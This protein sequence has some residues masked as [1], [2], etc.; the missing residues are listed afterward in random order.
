MLEVK[1][2]L[3]PPVVF[4]CGLS[5]VK[6]NRVRSSPF[7]L[8]GTMQ[9]PQW[10]AAT[11]RRRMWAR[12]PRRAEPRTHCL[13]GRPAS[14]TRRRRHPLRRGRRSHAHRRFALQLPRSGL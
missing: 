3:L 14:A 7:G 8:A 12:R 2:R 4:G 11:P 10:V 1:I 6:F 13:V 9:L 5:E